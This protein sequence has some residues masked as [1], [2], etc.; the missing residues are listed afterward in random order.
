MNSH[1]PEECPQGGANPGRQE[2]SRAMEC[3]MV[4]VIQ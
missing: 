3:V 1:R 2:G 4:D